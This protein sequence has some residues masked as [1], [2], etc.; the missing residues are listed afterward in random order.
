MTTQGNDLT[1]RYFFIGET[2]DA[3]YQATF[4]FLN[5][6]QNCIGHFYAESGT[7]KSPN[8]PGK[9]P[10]M[11]KC[12]WIIEAKSKYLVTIN[13]KYFDIENSTRCAYDYL[14]VRQVSFV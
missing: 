5:D 2:S 14:E 13:F 7:I 12:T 11:K 1:L 10:K 4:D 8:Y 9:Y 3:V 6:T